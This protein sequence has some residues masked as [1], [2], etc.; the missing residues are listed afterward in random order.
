M[1]A[2]T[3]NPFKSRRIRIVEAGWETY[4]G[5]FGTAEFV[6]AVSVHPIAWVEQQRLGG[7]IRMES[8]E[9]DEVDTQIGPSAELLR[10]RELT[11]EDARVQGADRAIEINGETRLASTIYTR[12]EL[13][14]IADRKGINGL[15]DIGS[16]WGVIGRSIN[17]LIGRILN[18]QTLSDPAPKGETPVEAAPATEEPSA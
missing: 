12:E 9:E 4:T 18:A 11:T 3:V 13:E 15:R 7:I 16:G 8:F 10:N 17:E 6:D 5:F 14:E 1:T 2:N